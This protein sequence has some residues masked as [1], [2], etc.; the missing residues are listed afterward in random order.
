MRFKFVIFSLLVAAAAGAAGVSLAQDK[1]PQE[2]TAVDPQA[3][4]VAQN[5]I[6]EALQLSHAAEIFDDLRRTLRDVYIPVVRGLVQGDYPGAPEADVASASALAKMLTFMDYVRKAGD[7]LDAA[8][9]EYR[10]AM[11]SDFAEQ[12]A[13]AANTSEL[14]DAR[15]LFD[16]PATKK[17]LDAAHAM[18]KLVTG[19]SYEDSRTFSEFSAWARSLNLDISQVIP[20]NN[21]DG[22]KPVPS[23]RKVLKAQA[24]VNDL[25]RLSHLDEMAADLESFAREVYAETIP[26]SPEE[27]EKLRHNIEQYQFMYNLQKAVA[28]GI[29]PSVVAA[30]LTDEQLDTLTGYLHAP[31]FAKAFD[32]LRDAVKSAT[33]YTKEDIL[34]AQKAIKDLDEKSKLRSPEE[35]E[36]AKTE[37]TALLDKWTEKLKGKISPETQQGLRQSLDELQLRDVPM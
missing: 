4:R 29:A 17:T 12:M 20:G 36:K 34:E 35:R 1:P 3:K 8:L 18:S 22:L 15:R 32:L 31:A 10:G 14:S 9:S 37:W 5:L 28:I 25:M 24:A 21:H 30:S 33:A 7:E 16:L 23:G 6:E 2:Q 19:F 27:R 13:R 26:A 11:I